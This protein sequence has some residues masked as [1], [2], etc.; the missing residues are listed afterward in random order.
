MMAGWL[1]MV[2]L[3]LLVTAY[4]G[5]RRMERCQGADMTEE[6]RIAQYRFS[7]L[8]N[9]GTLLGMFVLMGLASVGW[10]EIGLRPVQL[11]PGGG[12]VLGAV[13]F[14]CVVLTALFLYQ[15]L[16]FQC[17]ARRRAVREDGGQSDPPEPAGKALVFLHIVRS[18]LV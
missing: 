13:L 1:I 7:L 6:R 8:W 3:Y 17:S 15:M 11:R 16:A 14:L 5:R 10:E 2:L 12:I 18:G 9:A 4:V